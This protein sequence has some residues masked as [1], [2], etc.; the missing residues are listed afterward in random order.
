MLFFKNTLCATFILFLSTVQV[1]AAP[2]AKSWTIW[3]ANTAQSRN[4]IDHSVWAGFLQKYLV[5]TGGD[6]PN[7]VRYAAVSTPLGVGMS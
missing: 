3:E 7:L 4:R 2:Q 6:S 5:V 1:H